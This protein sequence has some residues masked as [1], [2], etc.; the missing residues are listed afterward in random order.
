M[1]LGMMMSLTTSPAMAHRI[2]IKNY[3]FTINQC[4]FYILG[5]SI[6]VLF[7]MISRY[8][9]LNIAYIGY[10]FCLCFLFIVLFVGGTIKGSHRWINFGFFSFQPSE[11]LKPFF[12][13]MNAHFLSI[14]KNNKILSIVSISF[15]CLLIL[16]LILQPD[17]GSA[18]IYSAIWLIQIFLGNTEMK[19]LLYTFIPI[20]ITLA[21]IGFFF[22]PHVHYRIINFFTLR[23]GNEQYQTRKAIESIYN[24]GLFGKG[25]GEGEVKYQLPD[26]HTDYI[27][28]VI[29][30]ELGIIFASCLIIY[31][32]FFAYRH[33][34]SNIINKKYEIRIIY[35]IVMLF[36]LQSIMHVAVNTNIFPSKGTT[37]PFISYGGSSILANSIMFGFLL[38]FTRKEYTYKSPYKFFEYAYSKN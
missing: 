22:F 38:A 24:G 29:C 18:I 16:L 33:M 4:I 5:I 15:F 13:I 21:V 19:V 30:E 23:G 31:L 32:L 35:G 8:Y 20:I 28:S 1:L 12:I 17:F 36:M 7:S 11:I 6:M 9:L 27:F 2:N 34:V 25:L 37:L 3:H 14:S 10:T 26:A